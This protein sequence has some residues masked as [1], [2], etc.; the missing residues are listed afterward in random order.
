MISELYEEK[1][2]RVSLENM[3]NLQRE[4]G[5]AKAMVCA[6]KY[7][8]L[9]HNERYADFVRQWKNKCVLDEGLVCLM[10][11]GG[12][13]VCVP[14]RFREVLIRLNHNHPL[15]GHK[16]FDKTHEKLIDKYWWPN[17]KEDVF[18]YCHECHDC[19]KVNAAHDKSKVPLRP[20]GP[21]GAFGDR[22]HIDLLGPL[23]RGNLTGGNYIVVITDHFTKHLELAATVGKQSE[24]VIWK[25]LLQN[26][27]LQTWGANCTQ[28]RPRIG[29]HLH[30]VEGPH[31]Q[32]RY[33]AQLL[34]RSASAE[35]RNS[36]KNGQEHG[37][38]YKKVHPQ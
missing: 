8:M 10:S 38:V 19:N 33:Q 1:D 25:C 34:L 24:T 4:C 29:I 37:G 27:D 11:T 9:P 35:Q 12:N 6:L 17:L 15:A 22:V 28:L 36:G 16:G 21:T 20:L 14:I 2:A 5:Y 7:G 32:I 23:P 3:Y 30:R 13:R 26:L 18:A 31:D